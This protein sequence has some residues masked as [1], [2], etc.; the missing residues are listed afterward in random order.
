MRLFLVAWLIHTS[1]AQ[2]AGRE[3]HE[4]DSDPRVVQ[5][6]NGP[7]RGVYRDPG[8]AYEMMF[9]RFVPGI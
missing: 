6:V 9:G 4:G 2:P 5:T 1:T 7:V 3:D 8:L